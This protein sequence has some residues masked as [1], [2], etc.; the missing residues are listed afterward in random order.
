MFEMILIYVI[1]AAAAVYLI[2]FL[3]FPKRKKD[4][5]A[6]CHKSGSCENIKR[7]A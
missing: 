5:C 4:T 2:W 7:I 1:V 3:F 6:G